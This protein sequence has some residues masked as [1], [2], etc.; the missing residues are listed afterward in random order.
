MKK[1][2][3][4]SQHGRVI[5]AATLALAT[6]ATLSLSTGA[7]ATTKKLTKAQKELAALTKVV[8]GLQQT[9]VP[10]AAPTTKVSPGSHQVA[11]IS[12]G[13]ATPGASNTA[14][15]VQ[16]AISAI[17]W[18]APP[19]YDGQFS[20]ST[21]SGD[22]ETAINNGAQALILISI[23]PSTVASALQLAASK[24]VAVTCI[25]CGPPSTY[26]S[27]P[28]IVGVEPSPA[29]IGQA[30]AD[31]VIVNSK[32]KAKVWVYEDQEFAETIAQTTAAETQIRRDCPGCQLHIAQTQAGDEQAPGIP[33]LAGVLSANPKGTINDIIAPYDGAAANFATFAAQDGRPEINFV[34]YAGLPDMFDEIAVGTPP[35]AKATVSIPLPYMGWAAIDETARIL[36]KQPTWNAN[37]LG[38]ALITRQN[39]NKF[40]QTNP[41]VSPTF[42]FKSL[43]LKLWGK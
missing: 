3:K 2:T 39:V 36:D 17:G 6:V 25:L 43:F 23:T 8:A 20:A 19:T 35:G 33:V 26:A 16:A 9:K 29:A 15:A 34:G 1:R 37:G 18:T 42:N 28:G 38:V 40:N 27:F 32:G 10:Q 30:Q 24:G 5:A 11:V 31:W 21:A 13:Q 41:Y 22:M 12:V 4:W 14:L 7:S